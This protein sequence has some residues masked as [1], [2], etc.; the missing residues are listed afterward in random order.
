MQLTSIFYL[1]LL[2]KYVS[3]YF[4]NKIATKSV[5]EKYFLL[6]NFDADACW[7]I[8]APVCDVCSFFFALF[9]AIYYFLFGESRIFFRWTWAWRACPKARW[10]T[11]LIMLERSNSSSNPGSISGKLRFLKIFQWGWPPGNSEGSSLSIKIST[12][13]L[14]KNDEFWKSKIM[15]IGILM[16]T[17]L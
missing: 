2:N 17:R 12:K 8:F 7:K 1:L 6:V 13:F 9:F 10:S 11:T 4:L 15:D 5:E 16:S 3:Q 14:R